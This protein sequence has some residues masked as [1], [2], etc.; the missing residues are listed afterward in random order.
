MRCKHHKICGHY[1]EN[2][3]TCNTRD[4]ENGYCGIYREIE[5]RNKKGYGRS[6]GYEGKEKKK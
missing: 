3:L 2:S 6:Y 1:V 4:A 5:I